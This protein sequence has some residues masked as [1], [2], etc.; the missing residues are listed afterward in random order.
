MILTVR[1]SDDVE[2]DGSTGR[3]ARMQRTLFVDDDGQEGL[4]DFETA[5]VFDETDLLE[6]AHE[7]THTRAR[8][9]HPFS[10]RLLRDPRG[11]TRSV[12]R[13]SS[14]S[15]QRRPAPED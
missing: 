11:S 12:S 5:A 13:R 9:A 6:L 2:N 7:E 8:R 1:L 15:S 3:V 14:T 4:I 10:E